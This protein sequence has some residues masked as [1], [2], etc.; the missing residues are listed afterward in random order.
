VCLF[1]RRDTTTVRLPTKMLINNR[2]E[3]DSRNRLCNLCI[4]LFANNNV[5]YSTDWLVVYAD[6]NYR[7]VI[8]Y[9]I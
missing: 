8:I 7:F 5:L 6:D 3:R 9:S 4:Y 1:K 2:N